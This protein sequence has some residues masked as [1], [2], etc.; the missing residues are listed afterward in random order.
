MEY[1]TLSGV[2]NSSR[3]P[4]LLLIVST[5]FTLAGIDIEKLRS[6]QIVIFVIN[7]FTA[8]F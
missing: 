8:V 4:K 5:L 6:I 3:L 2:C 1:L 7:T